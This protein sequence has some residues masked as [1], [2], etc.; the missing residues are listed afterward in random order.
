[1]G[2]DPGA[3]QRVTTSESRHGLGE[4]R[5]PEGGRKLNKCTSCDQQFGPLASCGHP[6]KKKW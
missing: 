5:C 1:M 4:E 6:F 3:M 2:M